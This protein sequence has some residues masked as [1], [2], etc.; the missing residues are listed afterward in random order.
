MTNY[1]DGEWHGHDGWHCPVGQNDIVETVDGNDGSK[2]AGFAKYEPWSCVNKF[3]VVERD[4]SAVA[5]ISGW[6][7]VWDEAY[8]PMIMHS[9]IDAAKAYA[10]DQA[11]YRAMDSDSKCGYI[12]VHV[13]EKDV[14]DE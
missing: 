12:I 9:T 3:R 10:K 4:R 1:Y 7:V 2:W 11:I 13:V 6:V 14:T 8:G 5:R